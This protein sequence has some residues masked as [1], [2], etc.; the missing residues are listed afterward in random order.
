M[1]QSCLLEG[2]VTLDKS[3]DK[4]ESRVTT[5][6]LKYLRKRDKRYI[7]PLRLNKLFHN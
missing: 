2:P 7:G 5:F 6:Q 1:I 4:I 3:W